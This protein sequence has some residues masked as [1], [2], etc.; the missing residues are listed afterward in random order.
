MSEIVK[1]RAARWL[2]TSRLQTVTWAEFRAEF[3]SFFL[4]PRYFEQLTHMAT[5]YENV[6]KLTSS[7]AGI[8]RMGTTDGDRTNPCLTPNPFRSPGVPIQGG[9]ATHRMIRQPLSNI[10]VQRACG[11]CGEVG[12]T[13]AR[14]NFCWDCGRRNILTVDFCRQNAPGNEQRL[15]R[16][17]G[18]AETSEVTARHQE[19]HR[20][21]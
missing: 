6:R 13:N 3:L 7:R 21:G 16:D 20:K 9:N 4:A 18:A 12:F 14:L 8:P 1:V 15:R 17:A 5:E 11:R 19:T 2:C 10:D